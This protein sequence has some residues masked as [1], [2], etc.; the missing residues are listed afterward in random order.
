M[1]VQVSFGKL[2]S[3]Y[4]QLLLSIEIL[5]IILAEYHCFS[6]FKNLKSESFWIQFMQKDKPY[7]QV[8]LDDPP[9]HHESAVSCA[10]P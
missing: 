10:A 4:T 8:W 2:V 6:I 5:V 9:P 7:P 3:W 1:N